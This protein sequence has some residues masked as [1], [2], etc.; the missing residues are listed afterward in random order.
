MRSA[1]IVD[2]IDVCTAFD[3]PMDD[4]HETVI[5]TIVKSGPSTARPAFSASLL[6]YIGARFDQKPG[7]LNATA[8]QRRVQRRNIH[9]M[10]RDRVDV[11]ASVDQE[12]E[13]AEVT[14]VCCQC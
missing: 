14:E 13:S 11:S 7:S 6:R 5:G 3:Q 1:F 8:K 9:R 4:I 10:F 2:R 12:S